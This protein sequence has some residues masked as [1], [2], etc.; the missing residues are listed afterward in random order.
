MTYCTRE[1]QA[2]AL[3]GARGIS[4]IRESARAPI[5]QSDTDT[6][7]TSLYGTVLRYACLRDAFTRKRAAICVL[8]EN[9][10]FTM[11]I[12]LYILSNGSQLLRRTALLALER[13]GPQLPQSTT[14]R[15]P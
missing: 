13:G 5:E 14:V 4:L 3:D 10:S 15:N 6:S 1:A 9:I 7:L 11:L 2:T 12:V 8:S